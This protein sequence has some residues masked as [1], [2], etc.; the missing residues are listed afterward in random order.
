MRIILN[1]REYAE[2]CINEGYINSDKPSETLSI[3]AKYYR[4][5]DRDKEEIYK[6]LEEFMIKN[7]KNFNPVKWTITIQKQ[8]NQTDKYK[9]IEIDGIW[10]TKSELDTI[11][12]IND[13]LLEKLFFTMLCLAKLSNRI[14]PKNN[15]WVN[16]EDK[17]TFKLARI[18]CTI[19][20][21]SLYI[22]DLKNLGLI[23]YSKIVDNVNTRVLFVDDN[24]EKVLFIN[25]FRELGYEYLLWKGE[26]LFRCKECEILVRKT[27]NKIKCCKQCAKN[28]NREK[29]KE[30]MNK[31]RSN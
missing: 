26:N 8:V 28:I 15:N 14:N 12:L 6:L 22:N 31:L 23:D 20:K 30:R 16:R 10:I 7:Y 27:N 21:Q 9:L 17:V 13:K 25:D 18:P 2:K 4:S 19:K 1:E 11:S 3:L 29:T 24:S 5:E